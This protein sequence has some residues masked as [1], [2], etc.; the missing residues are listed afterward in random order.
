MDERTALLYARLKQFKYL[1]NKTSGFIR[2]AL[3]RVENPYVACSFGK[4]SA[5][6]LHLVLQ[7]R[8]DIPVRFFCGPETNII[9]NYKEVIDWWV[10]N[11]NLNLEY[12]R[13]NRDSLL[14]KTGMKTMLSDCESDSF[15]TG[16]RQEESTQRRISLKQYGMFYKKTNGVVRIAPL[17]EWLTKDI[18]AYLFSN[19]IPLLNTYKNFTTSA[20]T[21]PAIPT[22]GRSRMLDQLKQ[23][24]INAFNQLLQIYPDIKDY[25]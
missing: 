6:M 15:F 11:Y 24:D 4:D 16:L 8:P 22:I 23:S 18:A 17:S 7:H 21:S 2:W 19:N 14:Q 1:V 10:Q 20:R 3:E 25:L 5:V 9:D 13:F 12:V